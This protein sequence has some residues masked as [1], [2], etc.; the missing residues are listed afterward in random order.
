MS[1]PRSFRALALA[2][3][4]LA[5][6]TSHV[7]AQVRRGR[8]QPQARAPWAPIVVGVRF[9]WEQ[10]N[11]V[12]GN[13]TL[14]AGIRLPVLPNGKV[15]ILPSADVVF[16]TNAKDYQYSI[17]GVW[18]PNGPRSG[19]YF[20]AGVGWRDSL[21]G[22]ASPGDGRSTYFGYNLLLGGKTGLG[23]LQLEFMLRWIFL[24]DTDYSP[25]SFGVG[26]G[27]PLW[28]IPPR[29]GAPG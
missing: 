23:P 16:L 6:L 12:S 13:A 25:N 3:T 2:A 22:A 19:V 24:N 7:D 11:L 18:A 15:E 4:T 21:I 10:D 27:L 29:D 9:G 14:G 8:A 26:L 5:L 20:G 1:H 28:G 17:D